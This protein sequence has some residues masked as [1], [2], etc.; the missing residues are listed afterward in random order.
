MES[1]MNYIIIE[2]RG[3]DEF[4]KEFK[5]ELEALTQAEID[6]KTMCDNDKKTCKEFYVLE[7]ANPDK[8]AENHY[9]GNIINRWK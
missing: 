4:T 6:W 1:G 2:S 3:N 7:S 8:Y 9:D 5:T